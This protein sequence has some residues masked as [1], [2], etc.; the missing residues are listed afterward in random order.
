MSDIHYS[1]YTIKHRQHFD[2]DWLQT[3]NIMTLNYSFASVLIKQ[4]L[5]HYKA[6]SRI[7]CMNLCSIRKHFILPNPFTTTAA[8][9]ELWDIIVIH[10]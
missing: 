6:R 5:N 8:R 1:C 9:T 4:I 7:K 10:F 2:H 3:N